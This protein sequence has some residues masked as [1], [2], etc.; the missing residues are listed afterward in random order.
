MASLVVLVTWVV[1]NHILPH[2]S[3]CLNQGELGFL[4]EKAECRTL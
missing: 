1:E 4:L 2:N 3:H